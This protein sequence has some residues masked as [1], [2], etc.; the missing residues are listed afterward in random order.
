MKHKVK[1]IPSIVVYSDLG[2]PFT[3]KVV[4]EGQTYGLNKCLTHKKTDPMIEFYDARFMNE[5]GFDPEGQFVSRYC[6]RTLRGLPGGMGHDITSSGLCL[7]GDVPSWSIDRVCTIM[8]MRW[9][10]SVCPR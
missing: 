10:D 8:V 1:L 4:R 5:E 6:L 2:V 7:Q 9:L 3:V